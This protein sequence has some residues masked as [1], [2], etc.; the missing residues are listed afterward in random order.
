MA[1]QLH[2]PINS[3]VTTQRIREQSVRHSRGRVNGMTANHSMF[4]Y[5]RVA[6]TLRE[7]C[8]ASDKMSATTSLRKFNSLGEHAGQDVLQLQNFF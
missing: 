3:E 1:G 7:E 5:L 4:L 8:S 6:S 2:N